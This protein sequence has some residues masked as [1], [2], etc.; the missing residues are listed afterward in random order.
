PVSCASR[1]SAGDRAVT[2]NP[3]TVDLD[4][5]IQMRFAHRAWVAPAV[6]ALLLGGV[7]VRG[8]EA[9]KEGL[10]EVA[11][12]PAEAGRKAAG[13]LEQPA[14]RVGFFTPFGIDDSHAGGAFMAELAA[15]L[16]DFVIPTAAVELQGS[17]GFIENPEKSGLKAIVVRAKLIRLSTGAEE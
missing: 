6:F 16:K 11:A 13:K 3:R 17:Y 8:E 10:R 7:G 12:K 2:I 5:E 15:A 1:R 9:R 4:E 14:V